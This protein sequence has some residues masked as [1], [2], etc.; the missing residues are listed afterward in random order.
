MS[1]LSMLQAG[2]KNPEGIPDAVAAA[3]TALEEGLA[4]VQ[5]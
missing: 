1:C 2:G 5:T 3:R 4:N